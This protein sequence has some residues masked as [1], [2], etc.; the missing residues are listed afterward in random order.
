MLAN[1]GN[2]AHVVMTAV[3]QSTFYAAKRHTPFSI[4]EVEVGSF[5]VSK[6]S[7]SNERQDGQLYGGDCLRAPC[8]SVDALQ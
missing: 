7:T 3:P 4:V 5:C 6:F 1:S 2:N 8:V